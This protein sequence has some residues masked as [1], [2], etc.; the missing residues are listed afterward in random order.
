[1]EPYLSK[2]F[3]FSP[4]AATELFLKSHNITDAAPD[5]YRFNFVDFPN[6]LKMHLIFHPWISFCPPGACDRAFKI[7]SHVRLRIIGKHFVN[8]FAGSARFSF[9][10][11][12]QKPKSSLA[13]VRFVRHFGLIGAAKPI[14]N[15]VISLAGPTC[16]GPPPVILDLGRGATRTRNLP[17]PRFSKLRCVSRIN[18]S[19]KSGAALRGNR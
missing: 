10:E 15:V 7:S 14:K 8:C 4:S 17:E 2:S 3:Q 9:M 11:Q 1:L 16:L 6:Y 12:A 5:S 19:L 18:G 13:P